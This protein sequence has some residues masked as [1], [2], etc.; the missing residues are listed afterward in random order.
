MCIGSGVENLCGL[1]DDVHEW[2]VLP[3]LFSGAGCRTT[4]FL[5][6]RWLD[7]VAHRQGSDKH[8]PAYTYPLIGIVQ[9]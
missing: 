5:D 8:V 7:E 9:C 3:V 4:R 6:D 1:E 2:S